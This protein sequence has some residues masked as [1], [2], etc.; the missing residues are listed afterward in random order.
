MINQINYHQKIE[1]LP[2]LLK[3][4]IIRFEFLKDDYHNNIISESPH[5]DQIWR[6]NI[7]YV[8]V[9]Q[10]IYD[11]YKTKVFVTKNNSDSTLSG[12][13]DQVNI[14]EVYQGR[15]NALMKV[16]KKRIKFAC[17]FDYMESYPFKHQVC[18]FRFSLV[19][20]D[21]AILTPH[22]LTVQSLKQVGH[23]EIEKWTMES[24]TDELNEI[25]VSM[26]FKIDIISI[27]MVTYLP[28]ILMNLINQETSS[29]QYLQLKI[30]L[31]PI[32]IHF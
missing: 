24:V 11:N 28:T 7:E 26:V 2:F 17:N 22:N 25:K 10:I 8:Y 23:Y 16:T 21:N 9:D 5:Y 31:I 32:F 13:N 18:D 27:F 30:L 14:R 19:G 20:S 6:P 3:S 4:S 1:I 29:S 15:Y 12:D